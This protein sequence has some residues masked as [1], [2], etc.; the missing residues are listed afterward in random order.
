MRGG[1]VRIGIL[2]AFLSLAVVGQTARAAEQ[3]VIQQLDRLAASSEADSTVDV[4][5]VHSAIEADKTG[6]AKALLPKFAAAKSDE[7]KL[8]V[9]A[10]ALGL[11]GDPS[12][13]D[14]I[15]AAA[16]DAKSDTLKENCW[17]AL[18][19][20]GGDAAGSFLL[21]RLE[22]TKD[23]DLRF[24]LLNRLAQMKYAKALPA[25]AEVLAKNPKSHYWQVVF[26]FGK[27]GDAAI[28]FLEGRLD[29]ADTTVRLNAAS[30]LGQWLM[31]PGANAAMERRFRVEQD[32]GV[33]MALLSGIEKTTPDIV[34]LK[35]FLD[36]VMANEK[37]EAVRKFAGEAL[38][39]LDGWR[40][41]IATVKKDRKPDG[42]VFAAEYEKLFRSAGT[43]GDLKVLGNAS[44]AADAPKLKALRERILQRDSDEAFYDFNKVNMIMFWNRLAENPEP[45]K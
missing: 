7:K 20:I 13:A 35:P 12:A 17:R 1:K 16:K 4:E 43:K 31:E 34:A 11:T 29:D 9:Y 38:S 28:P 27:M 41:E 25:T 18:A 8:E 40:K 24:S 36:E 45:A 23:E 30:A 44:T 10:W 42:V 14:P 33:R 15:I 5:A 39:M 21:G 22:V 32:P 26:V 6:M 3:D 19:E 2:A 37:D